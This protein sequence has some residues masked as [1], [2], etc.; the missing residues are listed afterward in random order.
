MPAMGLHLM[1][2]D[3]AESGKQRAEHHHRE[4]G[5][6]NAAQGIAR[7]IELRNEIEREIDYRAHSDSHRQRPV[8]HKLLYT[9]NQVA[10]ITLFLQSPALFHKLNPKISYFSQ[11]SAMHHP[12]TLIE[13]EQE[14]LHLTIVN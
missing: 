12:K 3:T 7:R 2:I 11:T 8:L 5:I 1:E 4:D 14:F 13:V 9:H 10:K 6:D